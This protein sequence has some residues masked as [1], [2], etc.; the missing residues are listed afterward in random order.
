MRLDDDEELDDEEESD[1]CGAASILHIGTELVPVVFQCEQ[2]LKD[3]MDTLELLSS[4]SI[5]KS[6]AAPSAVSDWLMRLVAF[7]GDSSI[8]HAALQNL[9]RLKPAVSDAVIQEVW[10]RASAKWLQS[11]GA[12][13]GQVC[14]RINYPDFLKAVAL[15]LGSGGLLVAGS[16]VK[17]D[18]LQELIVCVVTTRFDATHC[19]A[20][21]VIAQA[22]D[23]FTDEEWQLSVRALVCQFTTLSDYGAPE[24]VFTPIINSIG[25]R[26]ERARQLQAAFSH[27]LLLKLALVNTS[28]ATGVS[29]AVESVG[30][31]HAV[32]ALQTLLD[33]GSVPDDLKWLTLVA[34][35]SIFHASAFESG[36]WSADQLKQFVTVAERLESSLRAFVREQVRNCKELLSIMS[37]EARDGLQI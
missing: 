28:F 15:C 37:L 19:E 18:A 33:D 26:T 30:F 23:A 16:N 3:P 9:H 22:L 4:H 11:N 21:E 10:A 29:T 8:V 31:E 5:E 14:Y 32:S 7:S 1:A 6:S 35:N 34:V 36:G 27:H 2:D 20:T 24:G 17:I 13:A 12:E 25:F